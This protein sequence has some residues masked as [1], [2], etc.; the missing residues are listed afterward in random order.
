MRD[1]NRYW[2]YGELIAGGL[3]G[4]LVFYIVPKLRKSQETQNDAAG[5][6][7]GGVFLGVLAV[8]IVPLVVSWLLPAP[9]KWFPQEIVDIATT[10]ESEALTR[11]EALAKEID[12]QRK[13]HP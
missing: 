13:D 8:L 11:L 10:R 6:A 2:V 5:F 7:T 4:L 12:A 9:V 1:R 3:L